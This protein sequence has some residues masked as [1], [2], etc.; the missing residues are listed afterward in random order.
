MKNFFSL[1]LGIF[2]GGIIVAFLMPLAFDYSSRID[3]ARLLGELKPLQQQIEKGLYENNLQEQG[4]ESTNEYRNLL[5]NTH[6]DYLEVSKNGR[7]L[8]KASPHGEILI[9]IPKHLGNSIVWKCL[10]GSNKDVP[11]ACR[12]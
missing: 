7:I 3:I 4:I 1:I 9:M 5:K 2:L 6:I 10:G 11:V 12:K 8:V